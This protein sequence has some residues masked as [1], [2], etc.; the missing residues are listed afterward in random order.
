M[1]THLLSHYR[2]ALSVTVLAFLGSTLFVSSSY[3]IPF[4]MFSAAVVVSS[5]QGGLGPGLLAT[6]LSAVALG[7]EY[8]FL[9]PAPPAGDRDY[10]PLWLMFAFVGLLS[11]YLGEQHRRA[12]EAVPWVH[13]TLSS[14]GDAVI[15]ADAKGHVTFLNPVAAELTGWTSAE[16]T[17]KPVERVYRTLDEEA[18]Q[19]IENPAKK[20]IREG[21][22]SFRTGPALLVSKNGMERK[23]IDTRT[24]AIRDSEGKLLGVILTFHDISEHRLA[25]FAERKEMERELQRARSLLADAQEAQ[26]EYER[27]LVEQRRSEEALQT[28]LREVQSQLDERAAEVSRL[29]TSLQEANHAREQMERAAR[30]SQQHWQAHEADRMRANERHLAEVAQLNASLQHEIEARR[31]A[32]EQLRQVRDELGRSGE[33]RLAELLKAEAAMQEAVAARQ[34]AEDAL[35]E[36]R[37]RLQALEAQASE[38][39]A[40]HSRAEALLQE[41]RSQQQAWEMRTVE[42]VGA[43]QQAEELFRACDSRLQA[44]QARAAELEQANSLLQQELQVCKQAEEK[45]RQEKEANDRIV[46]TNGRHSPVGGALVPYRSDEF[47]WLSFN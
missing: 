21:I 28:L 11:S 10:L 38:A 24:S 39:L 31:H 25:D 12:A 37:T 9:S 42:A 34:R 16:A 1:L 44:L 40:G 33:E 14:L 45:L 2:V 18:R 30:E 41:L 46:E 8:R 43:R 13:A 4:V 27:R 5:I 19:P 7:V 22:A 6:C 20:V 35:Q 29:A 26:R 47:D 15:F 36:G 3:R 17:G 32:E 23:H